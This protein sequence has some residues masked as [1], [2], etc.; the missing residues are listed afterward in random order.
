MT[1]MERLA[2]VNEQQGHIEII[3]ESFASV[4][5]LDMIDQLLANRAPNRPVREQHVNTLTR[6]IL[7]DN[8][9]LSGEA[10]ILNGNGQVID[11]QHR[12]LAARRAGKPIRSFVVQ[13][14][15]ERAFDVIDTG[16]R[17]S[18]ND[19]LALRG[20]RNVAAVV[21]GARLRW[22]YENNAL[23]TPRYASQLEVEDIIARTPSLNDAA[24]RVGSSK[25][26]KVLLSPSAATWLFSEFLDRDEGLATSLF[27]A[28]ESGVGLSDG[29]PV[30]MLRERLVRNR[31]GVTKL[32]EIVRNAYAVKTWNALYTG[33]GFGVLRW[34]TKDDFPV[35]EGAVRS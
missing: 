8:W 25:S 1:L 20:V 24:S 19:V 15:D 9:A 30:L 29:D 21:G 17:R 28:L 32:P 14:T 4:L 35:I 13:T 7:H 5:S 33:K 22:K 34:T 11:G 6:D 16:P 10:I 18:V 2:V 3:D 27:E 12:L 26:V 31:S 23:Q